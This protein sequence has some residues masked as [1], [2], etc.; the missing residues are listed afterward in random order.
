MSI[1]AINSTNRYIACEDVG[2]DWEWTD[3]EVALF[4]RMWQQG[5]SVWDIA[6]AFE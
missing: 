5:M 6:K 4:D 3:R 2:I 1:G